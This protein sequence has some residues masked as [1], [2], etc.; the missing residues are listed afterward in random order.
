VS[1]P[2]IALAAPDLGAAETAAVAACVESG[3]VSSVG[4]LVTEFEERFGEAVGRAHA[5]ACSSGTAAIHL[6]LA[7]LRVGPGSEVMVSDLTFIASA[8]PARYLGADVTL[9]DSERATW[10]LDPALVVDELERRAAAGE[11]L[12]A[13]IVAVDLLGQPADL[14]ELL[15]AARRHG[16][17]VV[18]DA[19][20]ALGAR[21]TSGPLGGRA[22]GRGGD[23]SCFSFNGNKLIT[24]GGGGM[25]VTDDPALARRARHLSKQAK[26]AGLAYRHDDVGYNYRLTNLAAALG[27]A[28]LARLDELLAKKRDIAA[29]YDAAFAQTAD[30]ARPPDPVWSD[31]SSWLYTV[32]LG[33]EATRDRVCRSLNAGGIECR[34]IWSPLHEQAPYARSPRVGTGVAENLGARGLCL[35][36]SAGL[37]PLDQDRVVAALEA[38]LSHPD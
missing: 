4:P 9:I 38:A 21:W 37:A 2:R 14:G 32:L 26:V 34:P 29:R 27:L 6:A 33:D 15:V 5:V 16:V 35:P 3:F 24:T 12:P 22:V 23:V 17:P 25:L 36:S 7:A 8:N 31:R 19:S 10:N 13:A 20:E 1:S 28:Q 30:L 18:E 11:R